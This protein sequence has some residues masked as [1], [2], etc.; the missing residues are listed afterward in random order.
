[1]TEASLSDVEEE[2]FFV[3]YIR[4]RLIFNKCK[5]TY[6]RKIMAEKN[7]KKLPL[8]KIMNEA[9]KYCS[10]DVLH[11]LMFC[12]VAYLVGALAL[13]SWKSILFWPVLLVMYVLWGGFFRYYLKR[14]P[15]FDWKSL[16]YSLVPS[17]KIVV[18]TVVIGTVL[19]LLPLVPLFLNLSPEFKA[20]YASFIQG[21][22]EQND[23]FMMITTILFLL[24]S[25]MIAY[26]PFLA[27]ISAL[28]GR[29]G[30][31]RIAW[32]KTKGNYAEFLLI[33]IITNLAVSVVRWLILYCGGNDYI[34][35]L[36]LAPI[37][38]YFNVLSVKA[39]EFFFLDVE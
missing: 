10:A 1:M 9:A 24:V 5:R 28:H 13:F 33:G 3:V 26:R 14:K 11:F 7:I 20:Q 25:P 18:L 34:T 31:L 2:L 30:S 21:D 37:V 8:F 38:I 19:V 32:D 27:W 15:Y 29:S 16:L 12:I 36:F 4:Q 35:M 17:T 6:Q 23:V 22:F 39:Y